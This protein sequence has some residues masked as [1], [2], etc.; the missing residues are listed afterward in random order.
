[1]DRR[2]RSRG[3]EMNATRRLFPLSALLACV[4]LVWHGM[5]FR[6]SAPPPQRPPRRGIP[7]AAA[8]ARPNRGPDG[9]CTTAPT[10]APTPPQRRPPPPHQRRHHRRRQPRLR[11]DPAGGSLI[12]ALKARRGAFS[13]RPGAQVVRPIWSTSR[14]SRSSFRG[15]YRKPNDGSPPAIVPRLA[16]S[17]EI[18]PTA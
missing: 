1:M 13:T 8:T 14:S 18:T 6:P 10:A 16:S 4:I 7:T 9:R 2:Q 17:W 3:G 11:R 5:R 15:T 12:V